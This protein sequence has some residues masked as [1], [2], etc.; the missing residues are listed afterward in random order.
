MKYL[1]R[2]AAVVD[3]SVILT[4]DPQ[5]PVSGLPPVLSLGFLALDHFARPRDETSFC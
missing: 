1:L 4:K 3:G 5:Q 2:P